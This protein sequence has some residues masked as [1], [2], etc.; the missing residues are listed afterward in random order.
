MNRTI[1]SS[2]LII[3]KLRPHI[4]VAIDTYKM[5]AV[6]TDQVEDGSPNVCIEARKP[7]TLGSASFTVGESQSKNKKKHGFQVKNACMADTNPQKQSIEDLEKQ[8]IYEM[9]GAFQNLTKT[10][11]DCI[12]SPEVSQS[13]RVSYNF[14]QGL[15]IMAD[16]NA[17]S[18]A[19]P[20]YE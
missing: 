1:R 15:R 19:F 13:N 18:S 2:K 14:R 10:Q 16:M 7:G 3:L 5:D 8:D 20:H 11:D 4:L 6:G 9:Q 12:R 17:M